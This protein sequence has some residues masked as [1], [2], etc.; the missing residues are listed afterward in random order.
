MQVMSHRG[1]MELVTIGFAP[2]EM[3]VERFTEAMAERGIRNG[4]VVS[5]IGT[6]STCRLHCITHTGFPS[7][8]HFWTLQKPL[9]LASVSG[10]IADGEP[11]LHAVVSCGEDEVW[12]GHLEPGS[13]VCYLA[14]LAV[15]VANDLAMTRR[16]DP[17]RGVMLLGPKDA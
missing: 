3:L 7:T 2:G 11:H 1:E 10:L 5:G 15:L 6:L 17:E 8:N 13:K 14:E 16:R 12:A 4:V 9:E